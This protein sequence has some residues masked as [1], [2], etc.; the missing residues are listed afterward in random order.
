MSYTFLP[1]VRENEPDVSTEILNYLTDGYPGGGFVHKEL[2]DNP[3]WVNMVIEDEEFSDLHYDSENPVGTLKTFIYK[4]Y[5]PSRL[6]LMGPIVLS[7]RAYPSVV[8]TLP[9][10]LAEMVV[11]FT[12]LLGEIPEDYQHTDFF[13]SQGKP[14]PKQHLSGLIELMFNDTDADLDFTPSFDSLIEQMA[15]SPEMF[16]TVTDAI[17]TMLDE[18]LFT[19]TEGTEIIQLATQIL[20]GWAN[21]IA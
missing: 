1:P 21:A 9:K 3:Y 15:N 11:F 12:P 17:Y 8:Y 19:D 14:T 18:K 10:P 6:P 7:E 20:T 16:Q 5:Q 2:L 13:V 4:H